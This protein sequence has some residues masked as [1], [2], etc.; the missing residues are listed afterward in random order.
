MKSRNASQNNNM[1]AIEY[2]GVAG[3]SLDCEKAIV[4][5]LQSGDTPVR[6]RILSSSN[7]HSL[8]LT[9]GVGDFIAIKSGFSS[10]YGG[11]GPTC[12]S[13][14]LQMLQTH[15]CEIDE[16][17]VDV[18]VVE[19]LDA[20]ALTRKDMERIVAL[21][22]KRPSRW[23]DY[24]LERHFE[25]AQKGA[26]WRDIHPTVPY[27]LIDERIFDLALTFWNDPDD[28]M[29]KGYRRLEDLIRERTASQEHGHKLFSKAFH[30]EKSLLHW[31]LGDEGE[32]AGRANLFVGTFLAHR[33]PR[34]HRH[35]EKMH[36]VNWRNFYF[37][38]TSLV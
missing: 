6:A 1:A 12:F 11:T 14:V 20:S 16:C 13:Q 17:E 4:R 5:L 23:F 37:S 2:H 33:N 9:S 15:G 27:A 18:S 29:L 22:P 30:G 36:G 25:D 34:A 38:T 32:H 3:S 19:R 35:L 21:S 31:H 28:S 26:L 8:L 7:T 10:G 24:V